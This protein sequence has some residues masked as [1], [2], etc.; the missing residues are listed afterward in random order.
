VKA[1][2]NGKEGKKEKRE[3]KSARR[4]VAP[5]IM[6]QHS[7]SASEGK[8]KKGEKERERIDDDKA[9]GPVVFLVLH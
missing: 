1:V 5:S 9:R 6:P 4:I 8:K 7:Y 3:R 2:G